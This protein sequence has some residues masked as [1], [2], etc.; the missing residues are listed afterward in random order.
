MATI[1]TKYGVGD[2]VWHANIQN[3][4]AQHDCPDC[5]G[6]KKWAV[7]SPAGGEYSIACPR[8]STSYV[9]DSGLSLTYT[10]YTGVAAKRTIGS[11]RHD[12]FG[13]FGEEGPRNEY[14]CSETGVGGGTIYRECDLFTTEE[15]AMAVAELRA[16]E[17][18]A[19]TEWVVKL[20]NETLE[21]SDYQLDAAALKLAK[22]MKSRWGSLVW[23]VSELFDEIGE[24]ESKDDI[25]ELVDQYK[26][27][28][29]ESDMKDVRAALAEQPA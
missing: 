25:L 9:S 24:A 12:S 17:H 26:R 5:L 21:I 18:N 14:M 29:M 8:C 28:R 7:A 3:Q 19:K 15:E 27:W 11:V 4:K 1:E 6:A 20:Y 10:T 2:V 16:A 23:N 22:D 13:H